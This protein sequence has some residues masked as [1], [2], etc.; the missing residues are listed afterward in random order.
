[1]LY[2]TRGNIPGGLPLQIEVKQAAILG[3]EIKMTRAIGN[4]ALAN[5]CPHAGY[6]LYNARC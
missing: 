2:S 3:A 1:M 6:A 4:Y 5:V